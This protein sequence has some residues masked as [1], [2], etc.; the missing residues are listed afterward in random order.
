MASV[1]IPTPTR[2]SGPHLSQKFLVNPR[3][4]YLLPGR[5]PAALRLQDLFFFPFFFFSFFLFFF[6]VQRTRVSTAGCGGI[7]A[8]KNILTFLFFFF[9]FPS[10]A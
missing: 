6:F 9:F 7:F 1:V 3:A 10:L 5:S 2:A 8:G 4:R